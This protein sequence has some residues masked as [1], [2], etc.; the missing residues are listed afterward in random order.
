MRRR[1]L[2]RSRG[3]IRRS[4]C[5]ISNNT[6]QDRQI[7]TIQ[8]QHHSSIWSISKGIVV[9]AYWRHFHLHIYPCIQPNYP[10]NNDTNLIRMSRE[11]NHTIHHLQPIAGPGVI[12][13]LKSKKEHVV[14]SVRLW[15]QRRFP[16]QITGSPSPQR[17]HIRLP[18]HLTP[19]RLILL[20]SLSLFLPSF[21]PSPSFLLHHLLCAA[22]ASSVITFVVAGLHAGCHLGSVSACA[23]SLTICLVSTHG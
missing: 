19:S 2:V 21:L 9:Q 23:D 6:D 20:P 7:V 5:Y 12:R 22:H 16:R 8:Q 14:V 11:I 15:R 10:I 17:L 13:Q 18:T 4:G 3:D 1:A